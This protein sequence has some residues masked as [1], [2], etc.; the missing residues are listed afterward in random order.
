MPYDWPVIFRGGI[1]PRSDTPD[2][3][4]KSLLLL[5]LLLLLFA[6]MV[7]Y[8]I[9][10]SFETMFGRE[11]LVKFEKKIRSTNSEESP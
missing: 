3:L 11:Q 7:T 10:L 5:L 8:N 6:S 1:F 4:I 2:T 9:L